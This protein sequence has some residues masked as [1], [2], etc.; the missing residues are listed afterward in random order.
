M[1]SDTIQPSIVE[2]NILDEI[3]LGRLM[4]R[5][6]SRWHRIILMF[7]VGIVGAIALSL[8]MPKIYVAEMTIAP[9]DNP[10]ESSSSGGGA[11]G[12]IARL[13]GDASNPKQFD[14]FIELLHSARLAQAIFADPTLPST[15]LEGTWK[16]QPNGIWQRRLRPGFISVLK[17][18]L[19]GEFGIYIDDSPSV[20]TIQRYLK[21]NI[22]FTRDI[23]NGLVS[24]TLQNRSPEV[25]EILLTRI[26]Q[27]DDKILRD[28]K[29]RQTQQELQYLSKRSETISVVEQKAAVI[30]LISDAEKRLMLLESGQPYAMMTLDPPLAGNAPS[31]PAPIMNIF[32]GALIG[33]GIGIVL[34]LI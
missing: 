1:S 7:A 33:I 23:K 4:S 31:S 17:A 10:N 24:M 6:V 20:H 29:T 34:A 13:T 22:K 26:T 28:E 21:E 18:R 9:A 15:I 19:L 12:A 27:I 2:T 32:I 16:L 3:S 30:N 11:I 8:T 14:Y 5:L 25:A